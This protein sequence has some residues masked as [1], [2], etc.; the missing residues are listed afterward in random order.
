VGGIKGRKELDLG[1]V[2]YRASDQMLYFSTICLLERSEAPSIK[3]LEK[4]GRMRR[5]AKGD[6]LVFLA[7]S[8]KVDRAM[9][10][11]PIE[12]QKTTTT[13]GSGLCVLIEVF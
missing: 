7:I 6:D 2:G 12:D 3:R 9:A 10:F 1:N 11:V 4:M 5:H 13:G 8:L